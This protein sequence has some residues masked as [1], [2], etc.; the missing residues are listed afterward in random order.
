MFNSGARPF[1]SRL[2]RW[3]AR[4]CVFTAAPQVYGFLSLTEMTPSKVNMMQHQSQISPYELK[5]LDA[6]PTEDEAGGW[7]EGT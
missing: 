2:R 7:I 1:G 6:P 5:A 4:L 3:P